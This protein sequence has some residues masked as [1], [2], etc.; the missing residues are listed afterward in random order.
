[1]TERTPETRESG[2]E[3]RMLQAVLAVLWTGVFPVACD[4]TYAHITAAKWIVTLALTVL[5]VLIASA[6][7]MARRPAFDRRIDA[8]A[9][10][11]LGI[12]ALSTLCWTFY[13][14]GEAGYDASRV[15]SGARYEGMGAWLCYIC[16]FFCL[17]LYPPRMGWASAGAAASLL[18]QIGVIIL[19]Y[20]GLN[21]L[22]LYPK[23]RS[24]FTNYEFQGTI[25]NIDMLAGYLSVAVPLCVL[26]WLTAGGRKR[27]PMAAA[28][29]GGVLL[30]LCTGVQAGYVATAVMLLAVLYLMLTRP[31]TRSRGL[32]LIAGAALCAWVRAGLRFPWLAETEAG[33]VTFAPPSAGLSAALL[34]FA[35]LCAAGAWLMRLRR[36]P[37]MP[38]RAAIALLAGLLVLALAA[39]AVL[40]VPESLGGLWEL[41]EILRGRAKPSFGSERIGI[42]QAALG[43]TLRHPLL[44]IGFGNFQEQSKL[45]LAEHGIALRQSFDNPHNIFLDIAVHAGVPALLCF[46]GLVALLLLRCRE[47][48]RRGLIVGVCLLCWLAQGMFTF[49]ICIVSPMVWAVLGMGAAGEPGKEKARV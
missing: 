25:G 36:F 39:A 13:G 37:A 21:P 2:K 22:G 44:G 48:G 32:A 6:C 4:F 18:V 34:G 19:Q 10:A 29:L 12:M 7:M 9:G 15:L 26:P 23:G 47:R 17:S 11:L 28:G 33:H 14:A 49:S 24:V 27:I 41:H 46:L 35:V 5:T 16:V 20:A 38:R 3:I 40:P 1:M 42:W 8:A 30:A 45:W 43:L 31:E